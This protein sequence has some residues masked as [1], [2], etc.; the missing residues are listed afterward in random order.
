MA[1]VLLPDVVEVVLV[2]LLE[3]PG[4]P[5]ASDD[6]GDA[7]VEPGMSGVPESQCG[8]CFKAG[9]DWLQFGR[10]HTTAQIKLTRRSS[11]EQWC[12]RVS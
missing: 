8:W 12:L 6:G 1:A 7:D 3:L 4:P 10:T 11:K 9:E 5:R 2:L